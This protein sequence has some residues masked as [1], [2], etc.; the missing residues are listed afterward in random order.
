MCKM[1]QTFLLSEWKVCFGYG[2]ANDVR[3]AVESCKHII[4]LKLS[5]VKRSEY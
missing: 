1:N 2:N 4:L 3:A 5:H